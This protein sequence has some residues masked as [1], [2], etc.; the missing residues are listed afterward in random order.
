M[1]CLSLIFIGAGAK[2][3]YLAEYH[4]NDRHILFLLLS[5][6]LSCSLSCRPRVCHV[7][8]LVNQE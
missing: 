4:G 1:W 6:F 8:P 5:I 7:V 2:P 3:P